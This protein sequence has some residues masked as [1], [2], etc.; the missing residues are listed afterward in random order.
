M[1]EFTLSKAALVRLF[2]LNPNP[3]DSGEPHGPGT[4]VV[5]GD[6]VLDRIA[7]VLLNPQPLPPKVAASR[8]A[9]AV[10]NQT[11]REVQIA[12]AAGRG[13]QGGKSAQSQIARF[14]DEYCGTPPHPRPP[15]WLTGIATPEELLTA[16]AQFQMAADGLDKGALQ[17]ACTAAADKLFETGVKRLEEPQARAAAR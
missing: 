17:T 10:I 8:L 14:I 3:D 4:P 15:Y 12:E 7:W 2:G 11:I 9:R 1:K 6:S 16:A 13:E 5:R